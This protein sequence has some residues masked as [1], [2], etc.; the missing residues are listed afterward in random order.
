MTSSMSVMGML[1][2]LAIFLGILKHDYV[3]GDATPLRIVPIHVGVEGD[4]I[5][6]V[7]P[8]TVGLEGGYDLEGQHLRIE[9][10]SIIEVVVPDLVDCLAEEFGGAALDRLVADKD[11][12]AGAMG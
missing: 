8:P 11:V 3:V 7:E 1:T 6:S 9:G 5:D 12:K 10:I 4:H 2:R